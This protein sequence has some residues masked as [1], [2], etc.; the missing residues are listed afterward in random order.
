M[1]TFDEVSAIVSDV[2]WALRIPIELVATT[3]AGHDTGYVE[4]VVTTGESANAGRSL[5]RLNRDRPRPEL[6]DAVE[7]ILRERFAPAGGGV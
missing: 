3:P 5:F 2:A 4:V 7:T 6:Y 1:L